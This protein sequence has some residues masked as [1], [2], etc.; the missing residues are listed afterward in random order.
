MTYTLL[1][2]IDSKIIDSTKFYGRFEIGTFSPGQGLTVANALRRGLLSQLSGTAITLVQIYGASHEYDT[3]PGMRECILDILLNLKQ[4]VLKS[5]FE[6]FKPQIGFL[7]VKGPGII[8]ARDL[9]LPF[10][11][12]SINPDQYIATLTN[13]GSLNIKFLINCGKT[14][15][16]HTPSSKNYSN[17]V[18]LLRKNEPTFLTAI[19]NKENHSNFYTEWKKK[20]EINYQQ[21]FMG[22]KKKQ[23]NLNLFKKQKM[24]SNKLSKSEQ[25]ISITNAI[26]EQ[27]VGSDSAKIGYFPIDAIF[28]PVTR[29]NYTIEIKNALIKRETIFLEIWTNGT[30]DPRS[31]IHKT[32]KALIQLFLPLQQLKINS[33]NFRQSKIYLSS[34][35]TI[36]FNNIISKFQ[37]SRS[38]KNKII[39]DS[40][41]FQLNK[42]ESI[43][44]PIIFYLNT[45]L[46]SGIKKK[47]KKEKINQYIQINKFFKV[48]IHLKN[49]LNVLNH[50][51]KQR[52]KNSISHFKKL[53]RNL[54]RKLDPLELDILNLD[55]PSNLYLKLKKANIE[56]V[57]DLF[58]KSKLQ[59]LNE[60][61]LNQM[62]LLEI[63]NSLI[64]Y[65]LNFNFI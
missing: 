25:K 9:K 55:L 41:L 11:I 59:F 56:I 60:N 47:I 27:F 40:F 34:F 23:T 26:T 62:D 6:V 12:Y 16:I 44:K 14:S 28:S 22:Q 53:N 15:L 29:V 63:K 42:N 30:I 38:I 4:I 17:W 37:L 43:S 24:I 64:K 46:I 49:D 10:F 1:S 33:F 18:N 7:N 48:Q 32:V 51:L 52:S 3:L 20:R 61:R 36:Y 50:F 2:C 31:A 58:K 21:F 13:R 19:K 45:P 54:K 35:N 65:G 39:S 5:E 57:G 8:R